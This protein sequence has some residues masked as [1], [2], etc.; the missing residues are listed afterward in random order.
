VEY[1]LLVVKAAMTLRFVPDILKPYP[2]D[3][4]CAQADEQSRISGF[5]GNQG[6]K[7]DDKEISVPGN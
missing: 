7:E 2:D 1:A 6:R 4:I 5:G 3:R